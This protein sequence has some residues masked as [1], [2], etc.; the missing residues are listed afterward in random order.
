MID[1]LPKSMDQ[2]TVRSLE[3]PVYAQ[4]FLP[5]RSLSWMHYFIGALGRIITPDRSWLLPADPGVVDHDD[6]V[7]LGVFER[8]PDEHGH[9]ILDN[10][11]SIEALLVH[12]R[13]SQLDAFFEIYE[14]FFLV[15]QRHRHHGDAER[16]FEAL[17]HPFGYSVDYLARF[18]RRHAFLLSLFLSQ[19]VL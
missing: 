18:F 13:L 9:Q 6:P 2:P 19:I 12:Q 17:Y 11:R 16:L 7:R 5:I 1:I 10:I 14:S 3:L 15:L 8:F 4:S